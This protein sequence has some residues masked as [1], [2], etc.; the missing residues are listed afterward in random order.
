MKQQM[1]VCHHPLHLQYGR[2]RDSEREF[3]DAVFADEDRNDENLTVDVIST[4]FLIV[5]M[6]DSETSGLDI[7]KEGLTPQESCEAEHLTFKNC[8]KITL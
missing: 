2:K 6:R 3:I 5:K 7:Q 8:N 4:F 1:V